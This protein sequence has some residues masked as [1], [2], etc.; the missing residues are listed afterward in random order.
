M[1]GLLDRQVL[2]VTGKGGVGK[3]S[4]A[5]ALALWASSE[6]RRTLVCELDDRGDLSARLGSGPL[7]FEAKEVQPNLW[8]L[9]IDTESALAEYLRL[10]V[11]LPFAARIGPLAKVFDFVGTAA[12]GVREI[13]LTGKICW[14]AIEGGWDLIVVDAAATGHIVSQL[15]APQAINELIKVGLVRQQT[16]WMR[17]ILSDPSRT[18]AVV[19]STPEESPVQEA[20]QLIE[21]IAARTELS[22]AAVVANRVLPEL[23]G[24]TER[25]VFEA[26]ESQGGWGAFGQS[27][28]GTA[29]V[30]AGARLAVQLRRTGAGH[31]ASLR[32]R[33][34]PDVPLG[35]LP[36]LFDSSETLSA[37]Q[38]L[39]EAL[40]AEFAQ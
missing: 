14:E 39:A 30:V 15:G 10:F 25:E 31:L 3:T 8:G 16:G 26:L 36:D 2:F 18:G 6:G 29:A 38:A 11:R 7:G 22:V 12:P 21:D 35:L 13:L 5:A 33:I 28:S 24:R 19:V 34:P 1:A 23:F 17:D 9:S 20:V 37:T 27:P 32:A 40:A 4:V